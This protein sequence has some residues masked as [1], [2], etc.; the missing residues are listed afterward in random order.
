MT[1]AFSWAKIK[2]EAEIHKI[3]RAI[4]LAKGGNTDFKTQHPTEVVDANM[5]KYDKLT[6]RVKAEVKRKQD[7]AIADREKLAPR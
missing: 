5:K 7:R 3:Q 6:I 4:S 2:K 1:V